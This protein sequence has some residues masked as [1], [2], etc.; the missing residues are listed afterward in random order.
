MAT[1][2][3]D[4]T[5]LL[6]VGMNTKQ[7]AL[8]STDQ[9]TAA[10]VSASSTADGYLASQY[11][12]LPLTTWPESLRTCVARLA[13]WILI[14]GPIGFKPGEGM[15]EVFL[16]NHKTAMT[17]LRDVSNGR[18]QLPKYAAAPARGATPTVLSNDT[19]GF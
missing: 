5:D 14:S 1:Q 8:V 9:K 6:E 7:L 2:Y 17:W 11:D 3:A 19:N 16:E 18:V 4:A 10:L 13:A 15:H 12:S